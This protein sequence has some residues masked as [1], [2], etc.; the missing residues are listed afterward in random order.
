MEIVMIAAS[1]AVFSAALAIVFLPK[2]IEFSDRQTKLEMKLDY[3]EKSFKD[4]LVE[5]QEQNEA[6]GVET[7]L[8]VP[9]TNPITQERSHIL[10]REASEDVDYFTELINQHERQVGAVHA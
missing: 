6:S 5:L 2:L 7:G 10:T 3:L 1:F 9:K 4:G 8:W